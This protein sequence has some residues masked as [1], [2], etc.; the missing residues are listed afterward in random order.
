MIFKH[1][2]LTKQKLLIKTY[3]FPL[4]QDKVVEVASIKH[5]YYK[6]Q[7]LCEDCFRAKDWGMTLSPIW[8][9]CDIGRGL[10]GGNKNYYNVVIDTGE[11]TK[12]GFSVENIDDF[13]YHLRPLLQ[14]NAVCANWI[15]SFCDGNVKMK[16]Q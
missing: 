3:F 9:A 12:K 4:G 5:I 6:R 7:K 15:P 14:T 2:Q 8:W 10:H 16:A 11:S 1:F 13:L